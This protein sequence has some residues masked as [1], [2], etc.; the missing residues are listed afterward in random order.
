M[1]N[2]IVHIIVEVVLFLGVVMW[3]GSL[4]S[5]IYYDRKVFGLP[6]KHRNIRSEKKRKFT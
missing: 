5:L 1:A 6:V 3:A 2:D 4:I